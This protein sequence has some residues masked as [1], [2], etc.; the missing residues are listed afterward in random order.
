MIELRGNVVKTQFSAAIWLAICAALANTLRTASPAAAMHHVYS[1]AH[2]ISR[3]LSAL[4]LLASVAVMAPPSRT[5][6]AQQDPVTACFNR[7]AE[8][9]PPAKDSFSSNLANM[10]QGKS[11]N[12]IALQVMQQCVAAF[13]ADDENV[14]DLYHCIGKVANPCMESKWAGTEMRKVICIRAEEQFWL[15][16][17]HEKLKLLKSLFDDPLK[18]KLKTMEQTFFRY[19]NGKCGIVRSTFEGSEPYV[20]YGA[21]TTETVARLAIDL[22]ELHAQAEAKFEPKPETEPPVARKTSPTDYAKEAE[23]F[24]AAFVQPD[25]DYAAL[26]ASLRPNSKDYRAAYQEPFA[27]RLK[28]TNMGLW[29]EGALVRPAPDQTAVQVTVAMSDDLISRAKVLKAFPGGYERVVANLKPNVP[30]AVFRFV[31][32]GALSGRKFDGLVFV[33]NRWVLMPKPWRAV[34]Q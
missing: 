33:N 26:T 16:M 25:A 30:I 23:R 10:R 11:C 9:A 20:A 22:R 13:D 21:C 17:V 12:Q 14:P 19:R 2:L 4:L 3:S 8:K 29:Q 31:V 27:G 6:N 7:L 34:D 28:Q 1:R 24:L 15:D 5:A 32:P 18:S